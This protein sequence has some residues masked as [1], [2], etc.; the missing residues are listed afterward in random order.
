MTNSIVEKDP[1][2]LLGILPRRVVIVDDEKTV[3]SALEHAFRDLGVKDVMTFGDGMSASRIIASSAAIDAFI[4]DWRLPDLG[5]IALLNRIRS[6]A[7]FD[8]TPVLI[9]SG[10]LDK[11]DFQ[12]AAEFPLL[13]LVEKP[14][15]ANYVFKKLGELFRERDF[16]DAE[17]QNLG[18]EIQGFVPRANF[19]D[20]R[21]EI[22]RSR[23]RQAPRPAPVYFIA[24]RLLR[25]RGLENMAEILLQDLVVLDPDCAPALIELGRKKIAEGNFPAA[26]KLLRRAEALAP[27]NMERLCLLGETQIRS[28]RSTDARATFTDA[29]TIDPKDDRVING[30]RISTNM[31]RHM[32]V[33]DLAKMQESLASMLN[34]IGVVMVREGKIE[35]GVGHY[36]SALRYADNDSDWIK[37]GFNLG[38]A[39]MRWQKP[40]EASVWFK[41]AWDRSSGS[42]FKAK[43]YFDQTVVELRRL[44]L[45]GEEHVKVATGGE[46]GVSKSAPSNRPDLRRRVAS[47]SATFDA[48][49]V[50]ESGRQLPPPEFPQ[51]L[52]AWD[53]I[54]KV[55]RT[56]QIPDPDLF[57]KTGTLGLKSDHVAYG[58]LIGELSICILIPK[59]VSAN[60]VPH[61]EE[62][63]ARVA[64][65]KALRSRRKVWALMWPMEE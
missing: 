31:E 16:F 58:G 36:T 44:G 33:I 35:E 18:V 62:S 14:S 56:V 8:R 65:V 59:S 53:K 45:K 51:D 19:I 55:L 61:M 34:A 23:L 42:F 2:D 12:L 39:Y 24:I 3:L 49:D 32:G 38:L 17:A 29:A 57:V 60:Q 22:L 54:R 25:D 64:G 40:V 48:I 43:R 20:D 27:R 4:I 46:D 28:L 6:N 11:R 52:Y 30:L 21:W 1:L 37:L 13:A 50:V 63:E 10:F 47:P 15:H 9:L 7:A 26:T 41:R 5:G